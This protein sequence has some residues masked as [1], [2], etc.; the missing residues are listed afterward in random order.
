VYLHPVK[1]SG[2][3]VIYPSKG[4][5][6]ASMRQRVHVDIEEM[7][8]RKKDVEVSPWQFKSFPTHAGDI[9]AELAS[10]TDGDMEVRVATYQRMENATLFVYGYFAMQHKTRKDDDGEYL[11]EQGN[12]VDDFDNFWKSFGEKE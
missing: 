7:F 1:A 5:T 3:F 6:P 11:D 8:F 4:D 9:D 2:I 10:S 12:G